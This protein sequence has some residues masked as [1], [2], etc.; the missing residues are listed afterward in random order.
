MKSNEKNAE[1]NE[2]AAMENENDKKGGTEKRE[3]SQQL[4]YKQQL[5]MHCIWDMGGEAVNQELIDRIKKNYG[6]SMTR[7]A[8]NVSIQ[9]LIE[10]GYL[11]VTDRIGNAYVF[12]ALI[13]REEFQVDELKRFMK[14][15]F[16]NSGKMM[17]S[18]FMKSDVTPEELNEIKNMIEEENG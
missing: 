11:K 7:Q 8:M 13:D 1:L 18:A 15:T 12:K 17:F 2:Q 5:I 14:L 10:K 16:G 4:G 3:K 9:V 6:I